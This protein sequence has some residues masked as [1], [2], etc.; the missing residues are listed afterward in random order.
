MDILKRFF[1]SVRFFP[2]DEK[3]GAGGVAAPQ[4]QKSPPCFYP[5]AA[6]ATAPPWNAVYDSAQ[7]TK[8]SDSEPGMPSDT[9]SPPPTA[10]WS[11]SNAKS[12]WT[13]DA[14]TMLAVTKAMKATKPVQGR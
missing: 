2:D 7:A 5:D 1:V 13:K 3:G 6:A 9:K 8:K 10:G 12:D 4:Q 11:S 14:E